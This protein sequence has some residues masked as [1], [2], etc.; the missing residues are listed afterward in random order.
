MMNDMEELRSARAIVAQRQINGEAG[1]AVVMCVVLADGF[2]VE[3]GAD[4]YAQKRAR[5]LAESVNASDPSAF[6]FTGRRL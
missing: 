3:C 5:L 4:G 1:G 2:I 6:N